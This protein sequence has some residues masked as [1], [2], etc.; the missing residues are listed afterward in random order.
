MDLEKILTQVVSWFERLVVEI[1]S[2]T[3]G[4]SSQGLD[5]LLTRLRGG[6]TETSP[7]P[8]LK[9]PTQLPSSFVDIV[10]AI[11]IGLCLLWGGS[12]GLFGTLVSF[13]A[14]YAGW[15]GA[16]HYR[17][18]ATALLQELFKDSPILLSLSPLLGYGL[19]FAGV[20]LGVLVA[21]ELVRMRIKHSLFGW[22]DLVGGMLA[23]GAMGV[24]GLLALASA[25]QGTEWGAALVQQSQLVQLL[26]TIPQP[27]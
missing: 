9:V 7:I 1:F 17:S 20:A 16:G 23:G 27:P 3:Q 22:P 21:G 11:M 5:R 18:Q 2:S 15:W 25:L 6:E 12:R 10:G 13:A 4:L 26:R 8:H 14:L 24:L 19:A